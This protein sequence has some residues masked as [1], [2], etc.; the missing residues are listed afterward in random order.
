MSS[1]DEKEKKE[2]GMRTSIAH[3]MRLC[4][5]SF[6]KTKKKDSARIRERESSASKAK[7]ESQRR[8]RTFAHHRLLMVIFQ[9]SP[10]S[11]SPSFLIIYKQFQARKGAI[12]ERSSFVS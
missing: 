8:V 6:L 11:S 3:M 5:R 10:S 2:G 12:Q 9:S 4:T 7:D 1:K